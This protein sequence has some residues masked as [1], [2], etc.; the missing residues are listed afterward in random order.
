MSKEYSPKIERQIIRKLINQGLY[1][2]AEAAQEKL[3]E[4]YERF[5][6]NQERKALRK[7]RKNNKRDWDDS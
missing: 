4:E 3:D 7:A 5:L 1:D 2:E 6:E